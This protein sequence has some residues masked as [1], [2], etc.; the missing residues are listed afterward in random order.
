MGTSHVSGSI[1]LDG[2]LIPAVRMMAGRL[3]RSTRTSDGRDVHMDFGRRAGDREL[4]VVQTGGD[5]H[6]DLGD[7]MLAHR[8]GTLVLPQG[9]SYEKLYRM[10]GQGGRASSSPIASSSAAAC[11]AGLG[12]GEVVAPA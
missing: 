1:Q 7:V 3:P 9:V 5:N 8:D 6:L 12:G 11:Q 4:L 10:M 2:G